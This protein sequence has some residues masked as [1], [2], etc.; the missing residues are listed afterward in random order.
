MLETRTLGWRLFND[1]RK[2]AAFE[3]RHTMPDEGGDRAI[4][5]L[6][7]GRLDEALTASQGLP[8][9]DYVTRMV[10]ASDGATPAMRDSCA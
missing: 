3:P 10:A 6:A 5:L 9:A 4:A 7:A 1:L 2:L 8:I